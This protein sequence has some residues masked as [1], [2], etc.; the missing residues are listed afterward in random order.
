LARFS[1]EHYI[2]DSWVIGIKVA[3]FGECINETFLELRE[4]ETIYRSKVNMSVNEITKEE[5]NN[6]TS[7]LRW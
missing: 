4:I 7:E 6:Y 3:E 2:E 5:I 1:H